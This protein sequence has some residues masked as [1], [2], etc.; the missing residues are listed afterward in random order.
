MTPPKPAGSAKSPV[1]DPLHEDDAAAQPS[2][3]PADAAPVAVTP[4]TVTADAQPPANP[5]Q[6]APQ[7]A[8]TDPHPPLNEF[9]RRLHLTIGGG[10][11]TGTRVYGN[12]EPYNSAAPSYNGGSL[13][14]QPSVTVFDNRYIDFRLGAGF[15]AHFLSVPRSAGS[16]DASVSAF[17]LAL[18]PEINVF[19]HDHFGLGLNASIGYMG[20]SGSNTDVGAPFTATLDFGQQGNLYVGAQLYA[21]AW[22]GA[23][24]A[25][26]S[27]DAMPGGF[28]L[29]AGGSNPDLLTSMNPMW[30]VFLGVDAFQLVRNIQGYSTRP[31]SPAATAA[32]AEPKGSK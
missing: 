19:F 25:G 14:I 11:N 10:Y 27:L 30:T 28:S 31:V 1:V 29:P 5:A 24:R 22:G 18:T 9:W 21:H 26:V 32:P 3:V 4:V 13:F 2:P 16:V 6:A 23:F 20:L 15:G 12:P 8:A 17:S 7:A